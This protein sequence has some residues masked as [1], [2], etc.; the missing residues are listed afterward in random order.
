M[1]PLGQVWTADPDRYKFDGGNIVPHAGI[2][3]ARCAPADG[4]PCKWEL[5]L[6]FRTFSSSTV[7]AHH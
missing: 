1:T 6:I 4:R 2:W 5:A 3:R 7:P